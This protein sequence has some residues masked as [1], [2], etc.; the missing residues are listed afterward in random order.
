MGGDELK[1]QRQ[2]IGLTP[3]DLARFAGVTVRTVELW[4][5]DGSAIPRALRLRV[6]LAQLDLKRRELLSSTH[7]PEHWD[8]WLAAHLTDEIDADSEPS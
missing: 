4:E 5:A 7:D 6:W 3:E 2:R 8:N 1:Y